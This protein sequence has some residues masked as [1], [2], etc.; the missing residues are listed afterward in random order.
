MFERLRDGGGPTKAQLAALQPIGRIATATA[1]AAQVCWLRSF[2][3]S[4][5]LGQAV[6]L[7]GGFT[8]T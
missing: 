1:V 4:F 2:E 7:D 5:M 6:P 8:A 3:A